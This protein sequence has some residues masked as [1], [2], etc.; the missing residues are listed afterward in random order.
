MRRLKRNLRFYTKA[1]AIAWH[2]FA[3]DDCITV[4]SSISFV[5]LLAVIPFSALYL[6]L[7]NLIQDIFLPGLF[8][9]NMVQVLIE[10]IRR[11]I[12]FIPAQWLRTHLV[13][14]LGIGS[15]T[16]INLA[17]LPLISGLLFKSLDQSFR[18]IFELPPR[19][20]LVGQAFY[21]FMSIFTILLFFMAN[22]IWAIVSDAARPIRALLQQTPYL[23]DI[24]EVVLGYFSLP[25]INL[26][27]VLLLIL[28]YLITVRVFLVRKI[29]LRH[30]LISACLFS[31][32]W[33]VAREIFGYYIQHVTRINVLFGS[34][35]SVC[36]ILLWIFY[37]SIALLYSVEFMYVIHCGP[38]KLWDEHGKSKRNK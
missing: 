36:I 28:F 30:R 12:P 14:S 17:M 1:F 19:S 20:L 38:F 37:S 11:F 7:L 31:L 10:D 9:P 32:S 3:I 23:N 33:L 29:N 16:T 6:F 26:V 22:F 24:Y 25:H 5:F 34:L 4:S 13:D 35:G 27:S 21:A 8:P 18:R 2:N 15:F